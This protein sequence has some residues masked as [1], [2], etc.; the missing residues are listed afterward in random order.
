MAP[1]IENA[2]SVDTTEAANYAR[3]EKYHPAKSIVANGA[4][5][6]GGLPPYDGRV[7]AADVVDDTNW[8]V[9]VVLG[10]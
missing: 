10:N 9:E 3:W 5:N 8:C 1:N 2:F 6:D 4:D 7:Y